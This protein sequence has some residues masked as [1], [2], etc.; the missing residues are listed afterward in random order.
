MPVRSAFRVALLLVCAGLPA[1]ADELLERLSIVDA[2]QK[3]RSIAGRIVV[4]A[5]DGG[6]L[7]EQPDGRLWTVTPAQLAK[8]EPTTARFRPLPIAELQKQLQSELG[9]QFRVIAT[10][11]YLVCSETAEPYAKWCAALFERLFA[12]FHAHWKQ[13]GLKL[14]EPEFPLIAVILR[15]QS[16]FTEYAT[17][18]SGP[19]AAQSQGFYSIL[20][21]RMVLYDL[22]A[23]DKDRAADAEAITSRLE[24]RLFNVATVVH[25]ATHQIAFNSGLHVRLADNPLWLTEGMAMYFETPDLRSPTGWRTVGAVNKLRLRQFRD[26]LPRRPADSL[27]TLLATDQ[28]FTS[29]ETAADAYAEAWLLTHFLLRNRSKAYVTYLRQLAEKTPLVWD[30]PEQRIELLESATSL[31]VPEL[32]RE[33]LRYVKKLPAR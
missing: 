26:Y 18:D 19:D 30:T 23:E 5:Q 4:E 25:E 10:P 7:V 2:K 33:L 8:R 20:S 11:H 28:R 29:V 15:N 3:P 31:S 24:T 12:A 21:N 16:R 9:P 13:K 27:Q 22:T 17:A 6:L 14:V 1:R 32:D